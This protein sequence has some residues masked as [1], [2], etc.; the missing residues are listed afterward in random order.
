MIR[1]TRYVILIFLLST[2]SVIAQQ[3]PLAGNSWAKYEIPASG[4]YRLSYE[5]LM[6]A[7]LDPSNGEVQILGLPGGTLPQANTAEFPEYLQHVPVALTSETFGPGEFVY[8]YAEGP[9][10]LRLTTDGIEYDHNNYDIRNY[11][12]VSIGSNGLLVNPRAPV[13][14]GGPVIDEYVALQSYEQTISNLLSSGRNWYGERF[15]AI[16]QRTFTFEFPDAVEGG[17][18]SLVSKVMAQ[19]FSTSEFRISINDQPVGVQSI[20]P[21]PDFLNPPT[22]NPFRYSV[23]GR[24]RIDEFTGPYGSDE[25]NVSVEYIKGT[26]SLSNGFLDYILVALNSQLRLSQPQVVF[27]HPDLLEPGNHTVEISDITSRS[28]VWDVSDPLEPLWISDTEVSERL[29]FNA[30]GNPDARYVVFDPIELPSPEW[31]GTRNYPD[32]LSANPDLLIVTPRSLS[33]QPG[34]WLPSGNH[35]IISSCRWQQLMRCTT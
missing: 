34:H 19:S 7:G 1:T 9:D 24:E 3:S 6:E 31:T 26:G 28:R 23:K 25:I 2:Y 21:V 17:Q 27:Q 30:T 4:M 29:R 8:F 33:M 11:V 15:D 20:P 12:F 14:A 16:R 32:L 22:N 18:I 10:K 35:T 5:D 13:S